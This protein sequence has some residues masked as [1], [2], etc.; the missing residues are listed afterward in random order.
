[1]KYRFI[2]I[3][4]NMELDRVTNKGIKIF[5]G[6]R[7]SNGSKVISETM[8][9]RLMYETLGFHST[10]EFKDTVYF[11]L[12][13]EMKDIK[14]KEEM[15]RVGAEY[16]FLFLRQAQS[17]VHNLWEVKDNNVYVRDG[18]LL[19]YENQMEDGFTF[20]ASLSEIFTYSTGERKGSRF[21]ENE[22][23]TAIRNFEPPT[24]ENYDE[25]S[26]GGK[27][28][29]SQ[30]LFKSEGS[31]RIK[32]AD[33]FTI[34]ARNSSILPMKIMSYC[35]AL[36]CLFTTGK[37]EVNHK[38]AER[39]ACL[40]GTSAES[41]KRLFQVVKDAYNYRSSLVHGQALKGKDDDLVSISQGLDDIL[42]QLL[43][44][45]HEI[46]FKNDKEM[47]EFFINLLFFS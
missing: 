27:F 13:G 2:T 16:T 29:R 10:N 38:M 14:M 30:H 25:E 45:E 22:L 6:A 11:Y 46:F 31:T 9:T 33:Y 26:M 24:K 40:L 8:D 34:G 12:D 15:D 28:P 32:R 4:H 35:T 19:A 3:L 44:N 41:K 39:V 20:K 18:F 43:V 5:P 47:D 17:F 37:S 1:M 21:S 42:R 23:A 36:E 7:I